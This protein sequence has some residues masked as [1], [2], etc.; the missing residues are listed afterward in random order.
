MPFRNEDEDEDNLYDQVDAMA[1]RLG[2]QGKERQNYI[3]DHMIQGGYEQ[4]Q[5]R[6]SYVRLQ[7]DDDQGD[8]SGNRWG[9]GRSQDQGSGRRQPPRSSDD[10]DRF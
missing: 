2:L 9:F 4:V 6:E 1:T 10:G 7:Q 8:R 3:H 5:T